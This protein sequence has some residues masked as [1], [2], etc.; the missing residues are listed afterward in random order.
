MWKCL[1]LRASGS[2]SFFL[3]RFIDARAY[4]ENSLCLWDPVYRARPSW[5]VDPY[6]VGLLFLS[7]TLRCLGYN[8]Q[9]NQRRDEGVAEARRLSPYNPAFT[10]A[11]AWNDDWAGRGPEAP[12]TMLRS[13]DELLVISSEHGFDGHAEVGSM[14]QDGVWARSGAQRRASRFSC[15]G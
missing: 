5:P 8:D 15:K 3:G 13:A 14:I 9:A 2:V 11:A 10:L 6:M 1:G 4:L 7:I 12:Q